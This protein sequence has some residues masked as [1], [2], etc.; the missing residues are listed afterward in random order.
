MIAGR[1]VMLAAAIVAMALLSRDPAMAGDFTGLY[2]DATLQYWQTRYS[3]GLTGNL[4]EVIMPR[5][6]ASERQALAGVRLNVPLRV[7]DQEPFAFYSSGQPDVVTMSAQSLK[8]FDDY[9]VAVAWL[10]ANGYS[11]E[12]PAEYVSMLKYR[13][14]AALGGR[15]P[16]MLDALAIPGNALD[17]PHVNDI[18]NRIFNEAIFFVL[19]HELGHIL[20]RHPGY[21]PDVPRAEARA[22][23]AE[24]DAFALDMMRRVEAE[25]LGMTFF[26][27]MSAH[28]LPGRGDF[29]SDSDYEQF[30]EQA[31]HPLTSDRMSALADSIERGADVY[32]RNESDPAASRERLAY[33]V[34]QLREVSAILGDVGVQALIAQRGR[35]T[36]PNM[37]MPRRP[38]Q[39][40]APASTGGAD[41]GEREPFDG[42]FDGAFS[43][44]TAE[45]PM[46]TVLRRNGKQVTGEY[47]YGGG[48]G[49]IFGLIE[50]TTLYYQWQEG[51]SGGYGYLELDADGRSLAGRWGYGES[52]DNGGTWTGARAE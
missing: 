27:L 51:G 39:L 47:Y 12:T 6:T 52:M 14:P 43:D 38:G 23:E 50:G 21:G 10:Q 35:T 9:C 25:P 45:L 31:T 19:A 32:A 49:R 3:K 40:P 11:I 29:G 13:D 48:S 15:Y 33:I 26:Y 44:G 8:F 36:T 42:T 41:V 17:D 20:Y 37:L 30:L 46:R 4:R 34:S 28:G 18:A 16:L 22:N 7:P 24:A 2:D 1:Q 5:L